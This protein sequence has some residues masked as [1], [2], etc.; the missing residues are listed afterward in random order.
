MV[1]ELAVRSDNWLQLKDSFGDAIRPFRREIFLKECQV[2][3]VIE[4]DDVLAKVEAIT[5]GD[6]IT[7]RRRLKGGVEPHTVALESGDGE[8]IGFVPKADREIVANLLDAGKK[9]VAKLASKS[10]EGHWLNMRVG[11]YLED[12]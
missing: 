8:E 12:V 4:I 10:V 2:D 6:I 1:G 11:L 3:G 9:I 7:L 5:V